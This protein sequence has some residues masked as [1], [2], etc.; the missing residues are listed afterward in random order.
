MRGDAAADSAARR[1][2]AR[3]RHR[4]VPPL[5]VPRKLK[6]NTAAPRDASVSRTQA[7]GDCMSPPIS[8]WDGKHHGQGAGARQA[9]PALQLEV[10][11][12][13]AD[14]L[15]HEGILP[16]GTALL[17]RLLGLL[18]GQRVGAIVD[19]HQMIERDLGVALRRAQAGVAEQLLDRP[20][21][22]AAVEQVRG[23]GVAQRMRA[24]MPRQHAT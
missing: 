2:A 21:V 17:A 10:V 15:L 23:A 8:G 1:R 22:G 14:R 12:G 18:V 3:P 5:A 19:V 6:R 24:R 16:D 11:A 4:C 13:D 20:Q 7:T 9:Q